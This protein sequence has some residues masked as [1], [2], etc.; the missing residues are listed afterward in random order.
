MI[1]LKDIIDEIIE[2]NTCINCGSIVDEDLRKWFGKGGGGGAGGGDGGGG[3]E[4]GGGDGGAGLGVV[5]T[6]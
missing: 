3:G 1:N 6:N 2:D 4:G 5:R